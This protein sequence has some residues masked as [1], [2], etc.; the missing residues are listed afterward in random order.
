MKSHDALADFKARDAG[1]DFDNGA[2]HLV[3]E[4]AGRGVRAGVDLLEVGAA[5][6]A[7]GDFDQ[8]FA[9]AD[10]GNGH[11]LNAHVVDAPVDD[12]LHGGGDLALDRAHK[13]G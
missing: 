13:I 8:Q 9:G 10:L 3:A 6:A 1:A 11:H 12:G 5:D 7:G 4:D 2:G